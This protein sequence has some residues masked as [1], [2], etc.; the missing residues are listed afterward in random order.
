MKKY[1]ITFIILIIFLSGILFFFNPKGIYKLSE[2]TAKYIPHQAIPTGTIS[3]K[4]RDCGTCHLEIYQ[5]WQTSLHAKA[6]IDPFFT[7][8]LKKDKGDPTCS[9]CHTPLENQSPIIISSESGRY[10]DLKMLP[11]PKF[12]PELQQEGVTCAACHVKDG[13]IF[14][15]YRKQSLNAPHPVAYDEKFLKKSLCKQCHEVPEKDFSLLDEGICSTGMESDS[16]IWSARGYVCQDC[17]MPA[18][19]RPLMAGFPAR[20]GRKH[21]WP[22]AYSTSQLQKVFSF[23]ADRTEDNLI[24][25]ITNSGAG[26]K[27][28]TGDTDRFIVLDFFWIDEKGQKT[29]L[30]SIE[31]KRQLVWQPVMFV[32][33]DNR[34]GPGEST[35]I[36]TTLPSNSGTLYVNGTYHVMTERS[37]KRLKDNY[38]LKNEWQINRPFIKQLKIDIKG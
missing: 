14:G 7:A 19:N 22:G 3:L 9:V 24:I 4:A 16:G 36:I 27:A 26:H 8:Y 37:F 18:V 34:L 10:D 30:N 1:I 38:E 33:S 28:P 5:E 35:K 23:K 15:P 11:N 31:F 13:I 21:L 2:K 6:F 12:D 17:H 29:A 25:T 20:E 32:L